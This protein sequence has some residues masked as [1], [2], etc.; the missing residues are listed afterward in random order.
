MPH[1][2]GGVQHLR[3]LAAFLR[4]GEVG[5]HP[6]LEVH[7]AAHVEH[8]VGRRAELV[9]AR[10]AGQGVSQAALGPAF[11]RNRVGGGGQVLQVRDAERRHD[12]QGGVQHVH[13]GARVIQ[14]PVRG[15][16]L[17]AHE[18]GQRPQLVVG[19]LA[20][21]PGLAGQRQGVQHAGLGPLQAQGR[22]GATQVTDVEA[23]VVR[24]EDDV[25]GQQIRPVQEGLHAGAHAGGT[26]HHGVRDAGEHSDLSGDGDTGVD[27][28]GELRQ[29]LPAT[30]RDGPDLGQ[31]TS[32]RRPAGGL[33]VHDDEGRPL[34]GR[35]HVGEGHLGPDGAHGRRLED[36][37]DMHPR[38]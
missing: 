21:G 32:A 38:Q 27:Q 23:G 26:G 37:S 22:C 36:G 1:A 24:D 6:A 10:A 2:H 33:Q 34:Q 3:H 14:G 28:G 12:L 20:A 15:T 31:R 17:G 25:V 13:G 30:H 8:L 19:H 11:G 18:G 5:A 7:G 9:D 4:G 29:H 35:A 16:G